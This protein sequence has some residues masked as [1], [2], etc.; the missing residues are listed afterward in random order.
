MMNGVESL[1]V[2]HSQRV[3]FCGVRH[4]SDT[5]FV[6]VAVIKNIFAPHIH[7]ADEYDLSVQILDKFLCCLPTNFTT[8]LKM[9]Q[10][11]ATVCVLISAKIA[12]GE[13][14]RFRAVSFTTDME[15]YMII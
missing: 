7:S 10:L 12:Y 6:S 9:C 4:L 15:Y 8:D 1:A 11:L 14:Q 3:A 13:N 2:S 5:R